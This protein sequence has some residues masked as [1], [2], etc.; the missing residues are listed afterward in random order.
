[1]LPTITGCPHQCF[2]RVRKGNKAFQS[3]IL[4]VPQA[5]CLLQ[6]AGFSDAGTCAECATLYCA[7]VLLTITVVGSDEFYMFDPTSEPELPDVV[8]QLRAA[9][10]SS[11]QSAQPAAGGVPAPTTLSPPNLG[12]MGGMGGL[13]DAATM[14]AMMQT[15]QAR[16]MMQAQGVT[17][18]M[19]QMAMNMLG[20][21]DSV[22]CGVSC[23]WGG[24]FSVDRAKSR[25]VTT[26]FEQPTCTANDG[27]DG[28]R[29]GH[30][31]AIWR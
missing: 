18:D 11:A 1:M 13:P 14:Q 27:C 3:R 5:V 24:N 30:G 31:H 29:H 15:P 6:S 10:S 26:G 17:P 4:A 16:A 9:S 25:S 22:V 7:R 19:A 12:G 28:R 23:V 20:E 8:T 2:P 21:R